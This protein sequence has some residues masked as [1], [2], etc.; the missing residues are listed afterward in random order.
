MMQPAPDKVLNLIAAKVK[1][2]LVPQVNDYQK[3]DLMLLAGVIAAAAERYEHDA[4]I[5]VREHRA[6]RQI[7]RHA[8]EDDNAVAAIG[9][10]ELAAGA[11]EEL[12]DFRMSSLRASVEAKL[13]LLGRLHEWA[14]KHSS[15]LKAE[16]ETFLAGHVLLRAFDCGPYVSP[17]LA[18]RKRRV[19]R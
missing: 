4:D 18:E 5:Y 14:V 10:A 16:S 13:R 9:A 12:E 17:E 19:F 2:Q 6:M 8:L 15:A 1:T 7:F 11:H 3:G